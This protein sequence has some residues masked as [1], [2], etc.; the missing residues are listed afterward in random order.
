MFIT[1]DKIRTCPRLSLKGLTVFEQ[2]ITLLVWTWAE[3]SGRLVGEQLYF[4]FCFAEF[5]GNWGSIWKELREDRKWFHLESRWKKRILNC[6]KELKTAEGWEHCK[7][8]EERDQ[9]W[10][11]TFWTIFKSLLGCKSSFKQEKSYVLYHRCGPSDSVICNLN[12]DC[13]F[14]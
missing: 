8:M 10:R 11:K 5:G 7:E 2:V 9:E 4:L 12:V 6:R 3:A 1:E 14:K 13:I